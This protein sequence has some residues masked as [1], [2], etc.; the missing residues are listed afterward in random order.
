[1]EYY[2]LYDQLYYAVSDDLSIVIGDITDCTT[3]PISIRLIK[4][5]VDIDEECTKIDKSEFQLKYTEVESKI[6][7]LIF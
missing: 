2:K 1:M 3:I 7:S 4:Y 5:R 6:K